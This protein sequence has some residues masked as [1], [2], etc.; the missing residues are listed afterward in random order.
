MH[1]CPLPAPSAPRRNPDV[2]EARRRVVDPQ[3][4]LITASQQRAAPTALPATGPDSLLARLRACLEAAAPARG[5]DYRAALCGPL[6]HYGA[7]LYSSGWGCVGWWKREDTG[8]PPLAGACC[9]TSGSWERRLAS[10]QR[11]HGACCAAPLPPSRCGYNNIQMLASSLLA[12]R[13]VRRKGPLGDRGWGGIVASWH[14]GSQDGSRE[15]S[16]EALH[17][18]GH[19]RIPTSHPTLGS[20]AGGEGGA[21]WRGGLGARHLGAA[22]VDRWACCSG[23]HLGTCFCGCSVLM[24]P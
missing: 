23:R 9:F 20:R 13:P 1:A 19:A 4:G 18:P 21:V 7:T 6:Q 10:P 5:H 24:Q 8:V 15:P 3:P 12:S 11:S 14:R 17:E 2:L 16:C 22:G